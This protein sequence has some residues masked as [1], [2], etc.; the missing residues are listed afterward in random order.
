MQ[1]RSLPVQDKVLLHHLNDMIQNDNIENFKEFF[2]ENGSQSN[3]KDLI[4]TELYH[5][6]LYNKVKFMKFLIEQGASMDLLNHMNGQGLVHVATLEM[7]EEASEFLFKQKDIDLN[8]IDFNGSAPLHYMAEEPFSYF[9]LEGPFVNIFKM[10]L[11]HEKVNIGLLNGEGET[12]LH[13]ITKNKNLEALEILLPIMQSKNLDLN[14][15]NKMG[16]TA[17]HEATS[18][19]DEKAVKLLL[20]YG[21]D[22]NLKTDSGRTAHDL[23][24]Q[25]K[26]ISK[27]LKSVSCE[28][29]FK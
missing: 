3:L 8:F 22:P 28:K 1:A 6:T 24:K 29:N 27:L 18:Q 7:Y 11:N 26:N 5:A 16:W 13:I 9:M 12:A 2:S 14:L 17:L 19:E 15:K 4:N 21:L 25:S 23:A 20:E 10:L